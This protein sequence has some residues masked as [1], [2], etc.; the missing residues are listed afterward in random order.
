MTD[1]PVCALNQLR[2]VKVTLAVPLLL[3]NCRLHWT[4]AVE[5]LP[6]CSPLVFGT[7]YCDGVM[8]VHSA[9]G[10]RK[11]CE[12]IGPQCMCISEFEGNNNVSTYVTGPR[13]LYT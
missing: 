5:P 4:E 12:Q 2:P 8:A 6:V 11:S 13:T 1:S 9:S 3:V 10:F 7:T